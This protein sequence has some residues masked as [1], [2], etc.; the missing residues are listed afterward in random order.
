M[1]TWLRP[2][3]ISCGRRDAP[4]KRRPIGAYTRASTACSTAASIGVFSEAALVSSVIGPLWSMARASRNLTGL[5]P[6][7]VRDEDVARGVVRDRGR[8]APQ[9]EVRVAVE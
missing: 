2:F 5:S 1:V 7:G 9:D 8:D 3:S 6:S 4:S